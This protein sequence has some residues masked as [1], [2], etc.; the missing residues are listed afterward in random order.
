LR[1]ALAG[2]FL[3]R[4]DLLREEVTMRE[5]AKQRTTRIRLSSARRARPA[6]WPR[7]SYERGLDPFA[8]VTPHEQ[9]YVKK[10]SAMALPL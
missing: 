1:R 5:T 4:K 10:E 6:D 8:R 2:V 3:P 9:D 7:R